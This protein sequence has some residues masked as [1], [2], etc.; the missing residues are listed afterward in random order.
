MASNITGICL[1]ILTICQLSEARMVHRRP[2]LDM[3]RNF[4]KWLNDISKD[5]MS[6]SKFEALM[7]PGSDE[8]HASLDKE[9]EQIE[10]C[11]R[12]SPC[13][14]NGN[15]YEHEKFR[16]KE[17]S[18]NGDKNRIENDDAPKKFNAKKP[19][20]PIGLWCINEQKRGYEN[21]DTLDRCP[22]GLWCKRN[23]I[24]GLPKIYSPSNPK[25]EREKGSAK[26]VIS[27][28]C[29]EKRTTPRNQEV[30]NVDKTSCPIGLKC[31][32]KRE[33]GFES[34]T[35]LQNCPPGLWCKRD[36]FFAK[37]G[38]AKAKGT[39]E[40][41]PDGLKCSDQRLMSPENLEILGECPPGFV[42]QGSFSSGDGLIKEQS[43]NP[44]ED[45][46]H[47]SSGIHQ[48]FPNSRGSLV[49]DRNTSIHL[50]TLLSC[51]LP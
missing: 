36:E 31:S 8:K 44:E 46:L 24:N 33:A 49:V 37:E 22:P 19:Y 4:Q 50:G 6:I 34:Y 45:N 15:G 1:L 10:K 29:R 39:T 27:V 14:E 17:Q 43:N 51:L 25:K 16:V 47:C 40:E 20:C 30:T 42:C 35:S 48:E 9:R 7:K 28:Q 32:S 41:C 13:G 38:T 18:E 3:R 21:S 5:E 26:V 23:R 11:V 2:A 12:G